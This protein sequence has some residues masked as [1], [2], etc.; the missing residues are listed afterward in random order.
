MFS[1]KIDSLMLTM[2]KILMTDCLTYVH[3]I[4]QPFSVVPF[5]VV[6]PRHLPT[7]PKP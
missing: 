6:S 1:A 7:L 5:D 4:L 3:N 2:H